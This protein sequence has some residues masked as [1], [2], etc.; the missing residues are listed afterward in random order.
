MTQSRLSN[1]GQWI[2]YSGKMVLLK[3]LETG[4][5]INKKRCLDIIQLIFFSFFKVQESKDEQDKMKCMFVVSGAS[6]HVENFVRFA[7]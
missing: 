1:F 5:N 6:E 2:K 3:L 4:K 7:L